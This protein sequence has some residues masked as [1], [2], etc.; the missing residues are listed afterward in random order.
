MVE[1][2]IAEYL[3]IVHVMLLAHNLHRELTQR[4]RLLVIF[5]AGPLAFDG[6]Q[7]Q[8]QQLCQFAGERAAALLVAVPHFPDSFKIGHLP[9]DTGHFLQPGPCA[10]MVSAVA[11]DNLIALAVLFR[12]DGGGGHNA[13]FLD[14][15]HQIVHRLIVLH[16]VGVLPERMERMKLR[17]FQIDD[18][19][20]FHRTGRDFRCGRQFNLW[21]RDCRLLDGSSLARLYR[22]SG[23]RRRRTARARFL[24]LVSF[25]TSGHFVQNRGRGLLTG[26][27][28]NLRRAAC[29][30]LRH[31]LLF[32]RRH[33]SLLF[34]GTAP[35]LFR[36]FCLRRF[37]FRGGGR[38]LLAA[39][40]SGLNVREVDH[41]AGRGGCIFAHTGKNSLLCVLVGRRRIGL[42]MIGGR[43][44][45]ARNSRCII[46]L[47]RGQLTL[48]GRG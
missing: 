5:G 38:S 39:L 47:Q 9:D 45:F 19:S 36:L 25:L 15:P 42:H 40:I 20:L 41:L 27:L 32:S 13:V 43:F 8:I 18:F 10:A 26:R 3:F 21:W 12:A 31:F 35:A 24:V 48:A 4:L 7:L 28:V 1:P 2:D 33:R 16:L 23:F 29:A 30:G 46:F 11:R 6:L 44:I 22:L 14:R 37:L 17:H 34:R